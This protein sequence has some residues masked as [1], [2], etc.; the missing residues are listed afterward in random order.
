MTKLIG[1]PAA[2]KIGPSEWTDIFTQAAYYVYGWVDVANAFAAWVHNRDATGLVALYGSPP[3][4]DNGYAVY[5]GVSCTDAKWPTNW[6][7]WRRDNWRVFAQAPFLTWANAWFNAPCAFWPA[8]AGHPVKVDG[9]RV[10]SALLINETLDAATPY[11]GALQTRRTF[12][13]AVLIEGVGGTTH[14]GSLSGVACTDDRIAAYLQNRR[15][16]GP[17]CRQPIGRSM[18]SG[19][20]TSTRSRSRSTVGR[21]NQGGPP[22]FAGRSLQRS[23]CRSDRT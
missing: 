10:Q 13:H 3:F 14:A 5:L 2:G 22:A 20:S 15:P 4:D 18:Q 6:Q 11:S 23:T 21:I 19:P 9:R 8:K 12:P 17:R 7:T 16:T 1:H